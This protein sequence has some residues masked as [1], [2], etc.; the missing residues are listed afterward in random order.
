MG[1]WPVNQRW[2]RVFYALESNRDK[3]DGF[4]G[5]SLRFY[6]AVPV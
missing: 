2:Y 4:E 1:K 6:R 5:A 3:A